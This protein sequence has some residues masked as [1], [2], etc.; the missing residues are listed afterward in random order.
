MEIILHAHH[1]DVTES[2]RAQAESAIRRIASRLHRVVNAI[3][4]FI[5]D[6]PT[7][8]VEIVLNGTRS[9]AIFAH[10]DASE[11]APA[12]AAAMHRLESQ[13]ARVR[14]RQLRRNAP[15]GERSG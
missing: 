3:I 4:R 6:G 1:A 8:R 13:V 14:T 11:F 10:A 5:G 7:R 2:L 9:R 15:P 12:L